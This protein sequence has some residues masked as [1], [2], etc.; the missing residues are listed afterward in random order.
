VLPRLQ[1]DIILGIHFLRQTKANIDMQ[2]QILTLYGDLVG[3]NLLN[4]TDIIMRTTEAVLI[5]QD[6]RQ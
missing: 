1:F 2:S 5:P 6:L 3:T 4:K